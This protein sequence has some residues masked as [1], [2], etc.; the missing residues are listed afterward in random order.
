MRGYKLQSDIANLGYDEHDV[1]DCIARLV[2]SDF[3]KTISYDDETQDDVYICTYMK[4]NSENKVKD[5]LYI[6]L[7]LKNN[8]LS[9]DLGSFHL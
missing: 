3:S 7:S 1:A 2:A 6:K 8:Y 5:K 9:I 4:K